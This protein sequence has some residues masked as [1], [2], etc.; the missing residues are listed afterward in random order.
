MQTKH[1]SRFG[2]KK[3]FLIVA[4]AVLIGILSLSSTAQDLAV[5]HYQQYFMYILH[6]YILLEYYFHIFIIAKTILKT[7]KIPFIIINFQQ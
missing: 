6:C 5:N 4:T 7:N 1:F 3:C 2:A